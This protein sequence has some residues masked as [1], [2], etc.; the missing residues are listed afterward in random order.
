MARQSGHSGAASASGRR[1]GDDPWDRLHARAGRDIA[2]GQQW[3]RGRYE[4]WAEAVNRLKN[5][6]GALVEGWNRAHDARDGKG[7]KRDTYNPT[8][9]DAFC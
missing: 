9:Y 3:Y 5:D 8:G 1:P 7:F 6:C 2:W 4:T